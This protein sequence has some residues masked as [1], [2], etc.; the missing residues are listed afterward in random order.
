MYVIVWEFKVK[1]GK[2][3]EFESAYGSAG[4]WSQFFAGGAGY[5][6]TRLLRDCEEPGSYI[7]FDRWTSRQEFENFKREHAEK[8]QKLDAQFQLITDTETFIGAFESADP[9]AQPERAT[10]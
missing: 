8:Y 2:V 7:T 9:M 10:A 3:T 1:P 4:D 5:L 6:G